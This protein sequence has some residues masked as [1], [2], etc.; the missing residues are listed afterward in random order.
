M[1]RTRTKICGLRDRESIDAAV[2]AGADA[3]G[4][5]FVRSSPRYIDPDQAAQLMLGL[6]PFVSAVGLFQ[7]TP[8]D[9]F[10]EIERRCPTH[11]TQLHGTESVE[12]VRKCGPAIKAVM[13][14]ANTIADEIA[15]WNEI[16]EVEALLVDGS[17][18]G[19]GVSFDWS[20]IVE[21]ARALRKP[22]ILAG[23][24]T[25]DNVGEAVR[26]VRP[27]A[28]DVSSGVESERG[29]KDPSLIEAFC[30]AVRAADGR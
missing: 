14:D 12:L 18:G 22:L 26:M 5:V 20:Q 27:F 9:A 8:I 1:N 3:V 30:Q 29:V 2:H 16:D 19:R 6:P 7:N 13:F 11:Y 21:P 25:P 15:R 4:F 24:L 23:G 28:V 10:I 17:W